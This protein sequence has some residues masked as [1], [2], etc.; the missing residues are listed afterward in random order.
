M[1]IK[2]SFMTDES[3]ETPSAERGQV[4]EAP[5]LNSFNPL[6]KKSALT[7]NLNPV[8]QKGTGEI[9]GEEAMEASQSHPLEGLSKLVKDCQREPIKIEK[10][11]LL[12]KL[13][14]LKRRIAEYGDGGDNE[15]STQSGDE[16]EQKESDDDMQSGGK[17]QFGSGGPSKK[18]KME[19]GFDLR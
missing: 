19:H 3:V 14:D 4:A 1:F 17:G 12:I 2:E 9:T 16:E 10:S 15:E 7:P 13:T 18:F 5:T 8:E 6:S 11:E